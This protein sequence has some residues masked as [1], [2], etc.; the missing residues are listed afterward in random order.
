MERASVAQ[1]VGH[2]AFNARIVGLIAMGNQ[3]KNLC[4]HYFKSLWIRVFAKTHDFLRLV[5][6]VL[7]TSPI[8]FGSLIAYRNIRTQCIPDHLLTL[9][10]RSEQI[11]SMHSYSDSGSHM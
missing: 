6:G 3:Y 11:F 4:T 8:V 2:G 1:L 7:M 5:G 9:L 10:A